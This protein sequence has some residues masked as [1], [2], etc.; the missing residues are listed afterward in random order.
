MYASL[1][2]LCCLASGWW[3]IQEPVVTMREA[4]TRESKVESQACFAEPVAL[5]ERKGEWVYIRTPD[6]YTGWVP[7]SALVCRAT[8]YRF[9]VHTSRLTAHVYGVKDTEYGPL[10]SL[11]YGSPL[12]VVDATDPRWLTILLPDETCCYIQKGDVALES[13]SLEGEGNVQLFDCI[14]DATHTPSLPAPLR[15][16]ELPLFS[17][18]FLQLPYTWGGRSSFGYDCSGFVQML[19]RHIGVDLPRNSREQSQDPRFRTI[20]SEALEPGDLLFFGRSEG[21]IC[22][23]GMYLGEGRF[24]HATVQQNQPW[25]RISSLSELEWSGQPEARCPYRLARQLL[26][27][28]ERPCTATPSS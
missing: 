17:K 21:K 2:W 18:K 27:Q 7:A 26:P 9:H 23:V 24:I 10:F 8:P 3:Y 15:K 25:L 6:T 1:L 14:G 16:E 4:P 22:H 20:P 13:F 11:P 28:E 5:L 19:Y 12:H